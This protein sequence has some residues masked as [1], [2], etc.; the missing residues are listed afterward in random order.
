M[1]PENEASFESLVGGAREEPEGEQAAGGNGGSAAARGAN[2]SV[3]PAPG[4]SIPNTSLNRDSNLG[5]NIEQAT[6]A[7]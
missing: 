6:A 5:R 1:A 7:S 3:N 4:G 2:A